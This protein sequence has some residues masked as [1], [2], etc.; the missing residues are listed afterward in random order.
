[1]KIVVVGLGYVG[2]SNAVLLSQKNFVT[3]VDISDCK[4][5][6]VNNRIS[7]IQDTEI[8][9]FF[10]DKKINLIATTDAV[11][12]Y[13]DAIFIIIATP[14]DYD[15]ENNSFDTKSVEAVID[16]I[17][18]VNKNATIV[19]K[20][21]VPVGFVDKMRKEKSIEN[22]FFSPEFLREGKA[23]YDNLHPS[24]IIVGD[25][26][27]QAVQFSNLL[28]EGAISKNVKVILT[29]AS[30][31]ESIKLFANSYLAMRVSYFNELDS[32]AMSRGLDTRKIIDGV[33]LDPRIGFKYNNPSFGYGG[34][35]L[36][37]DS[38]Q[39]LSN[40]LDVPQ[41]IISAIV[42]ANRTRKDYLAEKIISYN[43]KTVGIYRLIMK[44]GSDNFRH[45]SIQGIMKRIK[46]KGIK[47]IV[48]EPSL[49]LS[50]FFGS[51]VI[52]DLVNFK[53]QSDIILANRYSEDLN[54]VSDKVF[55][56]DLFG[57]N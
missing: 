25:T 29:N 11:G 19:I 6:M 41:N 54:D 17:I 33:C 37:K 7:P 48:Y 36:P 23:L 42:D 26:S 56:R 22:I 49:D 4:V 12:A 44:S 35:C 27:N 14:T 9:L 5:K 46:A 38:K 20:S 13:K 8:S 18:S 47:V 57:V 50:L 10:K 16:E 28:L 2:L 39:L 53:N 55:S 30:E 32:Y 43:P 24:R 1:M 15:P 21:T 40:F 45:S 51:K 31:A 3:A 34:Y 52:T